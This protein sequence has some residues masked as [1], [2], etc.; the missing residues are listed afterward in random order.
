MIYHIKCLDKYQLSVS[1]IFICVW[2]QNT[3]QIKTAIL[4]MNMQCEG[5]VHEIKR[6]IEKI[7]GNI[8]CI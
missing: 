5:C 4:K 8:N 1:N 7:K 2:F 3:P 6:G